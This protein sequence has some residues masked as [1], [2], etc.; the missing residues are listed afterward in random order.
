[1]SSISR[2]RDPTI[3]TFKF[4]REHLENPESFSGS[5]KSDSD[6]KPFI[7]FST[8]GNKP[9]CT[10]SKKNFEVG[11]TVAKCTNCFN[12]FLARNLYRFLTSNEK[13]N[14]PEKNLPVECPHCRNPL[15][16]EDLKIPPIEMI[17]IKIDLLK[18][19][20]A[21]LEAQKKIRKEEIE[22]YLLRE[23]EF[24]GRFL[25]FK[26]E[27]DE[28]EEEFKAVVSDLKNSTI[29][30]SEQFKKNKEE[31]IAR[32]QEEIDSSKKRIEEYKNLA[33]K[34]EINQ[35]EEDSSRIKKLED[36]IINLQCALNIERT[37]NRNRIERIDPNTNLQDTTI[38]ISV[39]ALML[40]FGSF[41]LQNTPYFC[42]I[43]KY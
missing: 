25:N 30:S 39:C 8:F 14:K 24:V 4:T 23:E 3:T 15:K 36:E 11:D 19:N 21:D 20:I 42:Q 16:G 33:N 18:D 17:K 41:F 27:P 26:G 35:K 9:I 10:I 12:A 22:R 29:S 32:L 34:R 31:E 13:G 1:M 6:E 38:L 28:E 40:L 7:N 2:Q 37:K 5:S 43:P